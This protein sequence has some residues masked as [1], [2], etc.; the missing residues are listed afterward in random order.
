MHTILISNFRS[1]RSLS[2]KEQSLRKR[3]KSG[4][5]FRDF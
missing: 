2:A 1:A 5:S 4:T 3:K